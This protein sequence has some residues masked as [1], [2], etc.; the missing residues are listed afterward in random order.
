MR[1]RVKSFG[2]AKGYGIIIAEN[3]ESVFAHF[4]AIQG[5][6]I[7]SL[8]AGELVEFERLEARHGPQAVSIRSMPTREETV[9][10]A[11]TQ[12]IETH[13]VGRQLRVFLC[14]AAC[15]KPKVRALYLALMHPSLDVWFDEERLLPGHDWE[16]EIGR[17]MHE[18]DVVIICLSEAAVS[19]TGFVQKEI[20]YALDLAERQPEGAI[21]VIPAKLERCSVPDRLSRWQWVDI[22]EERGLERLMLALCRRA[23]TLHIVW[24]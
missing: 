17:A 18:T 3:G 11:A 12:F 21:C 16:H 19:K 23:Q 15:D 7:R 20:R 4:S 2:D 10:V 14:H 6:S 5:K 1:G 13:G 22:A 24:Q 8:V 9:G